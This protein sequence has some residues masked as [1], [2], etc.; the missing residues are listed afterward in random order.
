MYRMGQNSFT[1]GSIQK[2]ILLYKADLN[3]FDEIQLKVLL[4]RARRC[5]TCYDQF[6]SHL[7]KSRK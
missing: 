7:Q 1:V 3:R 5:L 4:L 2:F 6:I